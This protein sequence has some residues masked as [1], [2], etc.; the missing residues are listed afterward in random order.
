MVCRAKN[1][2]RV[3][4]TY[5]GNKAPPPLSQRLDYNSFVCRTLYDCSQDQW[6]IYVLDPAY[7]CTYKS[8]P[9]IC[10][11]RPNPSF[12]KSTRLE[13]STSK[14]PLSPVTPNG[15]SPSFHAHKKR[16]KDPEAEEDEVEQLLSSESP[17]WPLKPSRR[18]RSGS[19]QPVEKKPAPTIL[20]QPPLEPVQELRDTDMEDISAPDSSRPKTTEK[21]K[22]MFSPLSSAKNL[23]PPFRG[24]QRRR[25]VQSECIPAK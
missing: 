15:D 13:P 14:R 1:I 25:G 22:G 19:R 9:E 20:T 16:R 12:V 23:T 21:R 5:A 24:S 10:S 11:I 17:K 6:D 18:S 7:T 8:R 3:W 2:G 4:S